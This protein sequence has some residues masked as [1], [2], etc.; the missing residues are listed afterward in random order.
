V[1][2][3]SGNFQDLVQLSQDT[4]YHL[5]PMFDIGDAAASTVTLGMSN[6]AG[7]LALVW[8]MTSN[9]TLGLP[10]GNGTL[11]SNINVSA[12]TTSNN[13]SAVV[14]S[15]SNNVSFGLNGSTVTAS[16]TV[17]STQASIN[18]S[19]GTTSNNVSAITFSNGSNVSFGLN[20]S[21]VTASV[22]TSLTN[23]NVSA[24]TTSN[25]LSAVTFANS[26]G[27]SFGLNGSVV[28]ASVTPPTA[29]SINISAGTTSNN[30]TAV[31]FANSNGISF[32]INASTVTAALGGLSSWSNGGPATAMTGG[33][34]TLFFQPMV[35]P[36]NITVTNL[37]WLASV[38]NHATNSS[39]GLS[40]S[41]ALYSL[42]GG[43]ALSL[44]SSGSTNLTWTSGAAYSS[45]SGINYQQMSVNSW[46]ITPGPYLFAWWI[47]TQ[48]SATM[49]YYGPAQ[50]PVISSGQVAAMSNLMLN[51]Y[52]QATTNA[53]PSSFGLSNT[54]SYIRTGMTAAE[55]P[56]IIMQGT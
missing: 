43:T 7:S 49:S 46:A 38:T 33:Q 37:L 40:V 23:I 3:T 35:I 5:G 28:T 30:L 29:A 20:G 26:N 44:A 17:A 56:M 36:Y 32:G 19:A 31:T 9:Q 50:Q 45:N 21:V 51:G 8:S 27:V 55:Q 39:G 11:L 25:N 54:A 16:A 48:N 53:L 13:L 42:N 2:V 52:S 41:A 22:A 34:A 24:G 4:L 18:V 12:G 6:S 10:Q 47:S 15:N 14:F 1:A